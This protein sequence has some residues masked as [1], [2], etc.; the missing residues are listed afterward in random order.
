MKKKYLYFL[1][2]FIFLGLNLSYSQEN[3]TIQDSLI[4]EKDKKKS[5]LLDNIKYDATDSIRIDQKN[6]KIL[7]Y[8]NA[9]IEYGD[10]LLTSGLIILDYKDNIV[11][12]GRIAD[13]NGDLSQYPTFTQGGNIVNPDSI[14]YNFD[15]QK[16][17]IWNSKSEENGMNILSSL[18][19]KQND[20]VYYLKD[21]KVT[22][23]GNLL[24]GESEEADYFF[25]IRKGKL[26][27]GGNIITGFTNLFIK[28]V[29]TPIG[30]PFAYFPSQETKDSGFIIPNINESNE[31]GYSFQNGG[32]YLPVSEFFDLTI[33][34]DYYTNG[35]YG[36]NI[37]STY[38]KR[39]RNSGNFSVRYENLINSE[40]GLPGYGKSTVYNIRWTHSKDPKSSPNSSF[41]ASVNFGSSDYF[42][43]SV[44]QLNTANF[45]NNNLSSSVN[46]SKTFPGSA[47]VR[48][49]L[50]ANMSQNT[51]SQ[52]VN[53]T[54]P[55]L[56]LNSNRFYPFAR[57][58]KSKKGFLQNINIQYSSKADNRAIFADDLLLKK[59]MF[60]NAKSGVQHNIPFTT[61]FKMFKHFS[62]SVGG[63]YQ[64]TWTGKTINYND[65][66]EGIEA[67]KDT[68]SGFE[69]FGV[70]NFN[71]SLTTKVY[72][73]LN[74]KPENKVQSIRHTITPSISYSNNPSFEKYYDTYIVD[75]NGNTAEYTRFEGGL[76][77]VPGKNYSSSIGLSIQNTLEAKVKP[78]DSTSSELRKI[79]IFSNLGISTS[80]NLAADEFNLSPIRV[81]GAIDLAPGL[82]I[83]TGATFDPYG[84]DENNTR[85]NV[86]NIKNGGGLL[87]M[88]SANIS[89]QYQ[90]NNNT[91]KR[92]QTQDQIDESTSGGGRSDDLFG[93]SQ[94]FSDS[95]QNLDDGT[96][97]E[98]EGEE[99]DLTNY[100]YK[101]P[102]SLNLAYSLTYNNSIGQKDFST[103]SLMISSNLSLTPKWTVGIS[104]GYDFKQKGFTYTQ[105]RFDRDLDSWKLDFSW[106]PFSPRASWNFFIG[107][108]S[109]LLS[110]LKYEKRSE[111]DRS[112]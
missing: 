99:V 24:G 19:K 105:L 9:K 93:V 50:T 48:L 41:S 95:R 45:L 28:N 31:R 42:R 34:G 96:E 101:M 15:N 77:G 6:N 83:N 74:F 40:R 18:T 92:G 71:A 35:S 59:G 11:T 52:E 66:N 23:G 7:L 75:A 90:I 81:S 27:P 46:Y 73:I 72:G 85:I 94:D 1:I 68:I 29:P 21:G 33:L 49:S 110:D 8:N 88:T 37:S 111:P 53:L 5:V 106:V 57:K 55:T 56:T 44:N 98:E 10:V 20:S 100:I 22:T 36:I 76:F 107:I 12:A 2:I 4:I 104:S 80:Y 78:K 39:Y 38:R 102:W 109:G 16:A 32:Y 64:E 60:E 89:T 112:L 79:N 70:Y 43:Q 82:K 62:V 26:V 108:K 54:L 65:Y 63:Q 97:E 91:F 30:L 14:K 17:L 84:L 3:S 67:V 69:R 58:G 87:R 86:F 47:G 51:Q 61:N 13:K 25:K 103:N